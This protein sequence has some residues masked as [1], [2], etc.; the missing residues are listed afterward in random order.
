M[1]MPQTGLLDGPTSAP[2]PLIMAKIDDLKQHVMIAAVT[3]HTQNDV[4]GKFG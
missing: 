1:L 2:D 4:A 3:H